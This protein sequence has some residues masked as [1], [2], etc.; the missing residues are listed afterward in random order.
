MTNIKPVF[1]LKTMVLIVGSFFAGHLLAIPHPAPLVIEDQGSF[2][3]GGTVKTAPGTFDPI[4][5]GA[6]NPKGTDPSGQTLHG[7]HATIFYQIPEKSRKYPLVFWHGYGQSSRTWQT[8][9][10]GRE[11]FQNIFLRQHY[12]AGP[13]S[14]Y[15][16][17]QHQ[18]NSCGL[19]Y[20]VWEYGQISTK[21]CSFPGIHKH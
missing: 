2:A 19:G 11:G 21:M 13:L 18:T 7:D 15:Q 6:Y 10:D 14:I 9:P 8:T 16:Y 4:R 1:L 12:P 3:V 5:Q 17:R 20:F